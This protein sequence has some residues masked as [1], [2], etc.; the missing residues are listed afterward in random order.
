MIDLKTL[1]CKLFNGLSDDEF[2]LIEL[3]SNLRVFDF[4]NGENVFVA[5]DEPE[6]LFV[7]IEGS[8]TIEK[9][10]INGKR[11]IVN[12]FTNR[13]T[14]FGEV[15]LYLRE[16]SYDYTCHSIQASKVLAIPKEF[17]ISLRTEDFESYSIIV[18]NMLEILSEKA[19]HLNQKL[20]IHSSF[21]LRQKISNYLLQVS[22]NSDIIKLVFNREELAQ[23]IGTTRPS[24]SRELMNMEEE[25]IISVDKDTIHILNRDYLEGII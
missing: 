18:Q 14:V 3:N 9:T 13:G 12:T 8:V 23:Y 25:N 15:Y 16:R 24:L 20:L 11:T 10:D 1:N 21:S 19:F 2:K 7:L 5:G 6:F 17:I 4:N 22:G